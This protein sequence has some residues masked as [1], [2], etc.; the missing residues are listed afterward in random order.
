M[1]GA[2]GARDRILMPGGMAPRDVA[3][4][5]NASDLLVLPSWSEGCP[6]VVVEALACGR[7]VVATDVGGTREIV[8]ADN[9]LLVAPRDVQAL[10]AA[11]DHALARDWDRNAIA[12]RT[13]RSWDDVARETLDL[14]QELVDS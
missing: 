13:R 12:A 6:N 9:G 11:I 3:R 1:V 4:W 7:P 5:I 14:A 10:Q 2:S 8:D